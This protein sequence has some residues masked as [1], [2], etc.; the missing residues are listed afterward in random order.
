VAKEMLSSED[1]TARAEAQGKFFSDLTKLPVYQGWQPIDVAK[2]VAGFLSSANDTQKRSFYSDVAKYVPNF[3]GYTPDEVDADIHDNLLFKTPSRETLAPA[4]IGPVNKPLVD[5]LKASGSTS[6]GD[7]AASK[8]EQDSMPLTSSRMPVVRTIPAYDEEKSKKNLDLVTEYKRLRG[9]ADRMFADSDYVAKSKELTAYADKLNGDKEYRDYVQRANDIADEYQRLQSQGGVTKAQADDYNARLNALKQEAP[10]FT[11]QQKMSDRVQEVAADSAFRQKTAYHDEVMKQLQ[12]FSAEIQKQGEAQIRAGLIKKWGDNV[13]PSMQSKLDEINK[14]AADEKASTGWVSE[15]TAHEQAQ[16]KAAMDYVGQIQSTVLNSEDRNPLSELMSGLVTMASPSQAPFLADIAELG[17]NQ[18]VGRIREK[19]QSGRV[20]NQSETALLDSFDAASELLNLPG[21]QSFMYEMGKG[22]AALPKYAI[23]FALTEGIYKSSF[24]LAGR[25]IQKVLGETAYESLV[26]TAAKASLLESL[27]IKELTQLPKQLGAA[28]LTKAV[29]ATIAGTVQS[30]TNPF[31]I[32]ADVEQRVIPRMELSFSPAGE[33]INRAVSEQKPDSLIAAWMKSIGSN[34]SDYVTERWGVVV[35]KPYEFLKHQIIGKAMKRLGMD[36]FPP[37]KVMDLIRKKVAFNDWAGEFFE[38]YAQ[39]PIQTAIETGTPEFMDARTSLITLGVV[40]APSLGGTAV[41]LGLLPRQIKQER[42]ASERQA[43]MQRLRDYLNQPQKAK[44]A[45]P[46]DVG[47]KDAGQA[48]DMK[49]PVGQ[50]IQHGKEQE[51]VRNR[52]AQEQREY[53]QSK[54]AKKLRNVPESGVRG[55]AP[56]IQEPDMQTMREDLL[57]SPLPGPTAYELVR[58]TEPEIRNAWRTMAGMPPVQVEKPS[59]PVSPPT[60]PAAA[61]RGS[62]DEGKARKTI[63]GE[64]LIFKGY[65]EDKDPKN[66][67]YLFNDPISDSTLAIPIDKVTPEALQEVIKKSRRLNFPSL[68]KLR[69]A[70][71]TQEQIEGLKTKQEYNDL[72][73]KLSQPQ[74]P[75]WLQENIDQLNTQAER[76]N[77]GDEIERLSAQRLTRKEVAA[78]LRKQ[79]QNIPKDV[80]LDQLIYAVRAK[81]GIPSMDDSK[82]FENWL[83]SKKSETKIHPSKPGYEI[84]EA[85]GAFVVAHTNEEGSFIPNPKTGTSAFASLKEATDAMDREVEANYGTSLTTKAKDAGVAGREAFKK[86]LK[87]VPASDPALH[88]ILRD[89][90]VGDSAP[91]IKAWQ[92]AWNKANLENEPPAPK[93]QPPSPPQK[94]FQP[95]IDKAKQELEDIK[96]KIRDKLKGG[97]GTTSMLGTGAADPEMAVLAIQ[98][99]AKYAELGVLKFSQFAAEMVKDFGEAIKPYLKAAYGGASYSVDEDTRKQMDD[100]GTVRAFNLDSLKQE[101]DEEPADPFPLFIARIKKEMAERLK[102]MNKVDLRKIGAEYGIDDENVIKELTETAIVERARE[103]IAENPD[104]LDALKALIALYDRQPSLTHRTSESIAKQQYSTPAPLAFIAGAFTRVNGF[105]AIEPSAGNGM[106]TIGYDPQ[107]VWVNEID[108][109]RRANL[110]TQGF[111]FVTNQDA[112]TSGLETLKSTS[113]KVGNLIWNIVTNPPFGTNAESIPT[114]FDGYE[115]IKDD[116]VMTARSLRLMG[117]NARA[118]IIIGGNNEYN[119]DKR[120]RNDRIFFNWLYHF[121]N[122]NAIINVSGDLFRKQGASFPIRLI[123]VQGKKEKPEGA[124]PLRSDEGEKVYTS[125][126]DIY[127]RMKEVLHARPVVVQPSDNAE[128]GGGRPVRPSGRPQNGGGRTPT[129]RPETPATG[130][131]NGGSGSTPGSTGGG[132]STGTGNTRPVRQPQGGSTATNG[133]IQGTRGSLQP[134]EPITL[135]P[136]EQRQFDERRS[137]RDLERANTLESAG[138]DSLEVPYIPQSFGKRMSAMVPRSMAFDTY[139]AMNQLEDVVGSIDHFVLSELKYGSMEELY[140][141]LSADQIDAVAM[142]IRNIQIG[143]GSIVGDMT[144]T[145]KG[146]VAASVIRWAAKHGF[147]PIFFTK[148]KELFSDLYRDLVDTGN[149]DL[150]PFIVNSNVNI[151]D[152]FGDEI[153]PKMNAGKAKRVLETGD[154][155]GYDFVLATYSQVQN[156]DTYVT[157]PAFLQQI[158]PGSIIIMDESHNA[159]GKESNIGNEFAAYIDNSH[160]VVYLSATYAKRTDNM[161]VYIYK[162]VLREANATSDEIIDSIARGGVAMQEAIAADLTRSGQMIRR[163]RSFDGIAVDWKVLDQHKEQHTKTVDAVTKLIRD[164]IAFQQDYVAPVIGQMDEDAAEEGE[165]AAVGGRQ[166]TNLASVDNAPFV[167]KVHNVIDQLL[168]S[169]K[170]DDVAQ[171]AIAAVKNGEKPVIFF[172]NTMEAF[173]QDLGYNPGETVHNTDFA[174]VL[175]RGLK[176]VLRYTIRDAAGKQTHAALTP[177]QLGARGLAKFNEIASEIEKTSSGI[178]LSPIDRLRFL[179]GKQGIKVGEVTGRKITLKMSESGKA[180]V[181]HRKEK[182]E[183]KT[184]REFNN[185]G[186]DVLLLNVSGGTGASAHSSPKF[187]DKRPRVGI[188]HQPEL[189]ISEEMQKRGRINRFGQV[190]LPRYVYMSSAIPAERRIMMMLAGKLKSLDANT[191]SRQKSAMSLEG[192]V[193]FM[194]KYGDE[195]V[196]QYIKEDRDLAERLLDPFKFADKSDDE[197]EN[198]STAPNAV[199]RATN[200]VAL[201]P[202][203]EQDKFYDDVSQRYRDHLEYLNE[204]GENDL[205]L[206]ALPLNAKT[207]QKTVIRAG[208][209]GRSVF[210]T[211]SYLQTVEVDVLRKPWKKDE[212]KKMV[213]KELGKRTPEE[214][215]SEMLDDANAFAEEWQRK[216]LA[217][218]NPDNPLF[219]IRQ[220][221]L[222]SRLNA[223][224]RRT[225]DLIQ[226]FKIGTA[227]PMPTDFNDP[228]HSEFSPAFFMGFVINKKATNPYAPSA[229]KLRFAVNDFRRYVPIPGGKAALVNAILAGA[230]TYSWKQQRNDMISKWDERHTQAK[231]EQLAIV[232]GNILQGY[233]TDIAQHGKLISYTTNDGGTERGILLP[234]NQTVDVPDSVNVP[235]GRAMPYFESIARRD[236]IQTRLGAIFQKDSGGGWIL[237]V[238]ASKEKGGKFFLDDELAGLT[239]QGRFDKSGQFMTASVDAEKLKDVVELFHNKHHDTVNVPR[240]WSDTHLDSIGDSPDGNMYALPIV[241]SFYDKLLAPVSHHIAVAIAR[242]VQA[243]PESIQ[244][245]LRAAFAQSPEIRAAYEELR[246]TVSEYRLSINKLSRMVLGRDASSEEFI[247]LDRL[248]RG[249]PADFEKLKP[250]IQAAWRPIGSKWHELAQQLTMEMSLL[251]LPIREEWL[252]GPQHWYPNIWKH[253]FSRMVLG[254]LIGPNGRNLKVR[255]AEWGHTM[256][257]VVDKFAVYDQ[258]GDL[259]RTGTRLAI[260]DTMEEAQA[261]VKENGGYRIRYT[262]RETGKA[263]EETFDTPQERAKIVKQLYEDEAVRG[264]ISTPKGIHLTIMEPMTLEQ[265]IGHGLLEDPLINMRRGIREVGGLIAKTRFYTK[266]GQSAVIDDISTLPEDE[267]KNYVKLDDVKFKIPEKIA[268]ANEWTQRLTDGWV[269][270]SL[271]ED[272]MALYGPKGFGS[273][274]YDGLTRFLKSGLTVYNPF[275]Y[276]KQPVENELSLWFADS[277]LVLNIPAQTMAFTEYLD[278]IIRGTPNDFYDLFIKLGGDK[279]D[280]YTAEMRRYGKDISTFRDIEGSTAP[281]SFAEKAD[282]WLEQK[283]LYNYFADKADLLKAIYHHEDVIYRYYAFKRW[284]QKGMT[285]KQAMARVENS[286]FYAKETP[287][288]ITVISRHIPFAPRVTY[289]FGRIILTRLRDYPASTIMKLGLMAYLYDWLRDEMMKE[290]GWDDKAIQ[291]MGK[292]APSW[293]EIPLP[294]TD[295]QG[296]TVIMNLQWLLPFGELGMI[297]WDRQQDITAN[298]FRYMPLFFKGAVSTATGKTPWGYD[299]AKEGDPDWKKK[300]TV[301][302]LTQYMPYI[303]GTYWVQQYK[304]AASKAAPFSDWIEPTQKEYQV[305]WTEKAFVAPALG[306]L[307]HENMRTMVAKAQ[308]YV[309][310]QLKF[311]EDEK[312]AIE[313]DPNRASDITDVQRHNAR[314]AALLSQTA[315]EY[316]VPVTPELF[317]RY[318]IDVGTALQ[319]SMNKKQERMMSSPLERSF[320]R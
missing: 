53:Q 305:P 104:E 118:G 219:A 71:A 23:E 264:T 89:V 316:R 156:P 310:T 312:R 227:W 19:E 22:V 194:N 12:G 139:A 192:Q 79:G 95:N 114:D 144:G 268:N 87:S 26:Q 262:E 314:A 180:L 35:E 243:A 290:Q 126:E 222:I 199:R 318:I 204:A 88:E 234:R 11:E 166:G 237:K 251:G 141:A 21:V 198:S 281:L 200:R 247:A 82:E 84:R 33:I 188:I 46:P 239:R 190:T 2:D 186:L 15:D 129:V 29:P 119:D 224:Q 92:D 303:L 291:R 230:G 45:F 18:M 228:D 252:S 307:R 6:I 223:Q 99:A 294:I 205:E 253:H 195:I 226:S 64:G 309:M 14:K 220:A 50:F 3:S 274:L 136:Q 151:V 176:G 308:S 49:N 269:P 209:G 295:S 68:Q 319:K 285:P 74:S 215:Q 299:I 98:A 217:K 130:A 157:K 7:I 206:K 109:V 132:T 167:N 276:V 292:A 148:K 4:P 283:K 302:L 128:P 277:E 163:Q 48:P 225:A 44:L 254:H 231:R 54:Q 245:W 113:R 8:L 270:K 30:F 56:T 259:A 202:V 246:Q 122:V 59:S 300:A 91:I 24:K 293:T 73:K 110:S 77:L 108:P 34:A 32:A 236:N 177:D 284:V 85:N 133:V 178:S 196:Y 315:K 288:F 261:F 140:T 120:L 60:A 172:R 161:P 179:L 214:I 207:L 72:L 313:S 298:A 152:E 135:T 221:G 235:I 311:L 131:G 250:E 158:T 123:L 107:N 271:A 146:R 1:I 267:K 169:L 102:A 242:I 36:V 41:R 171:E 187:K 191:T 142:A 193:D 182:D 127:N 47:L 57:N 173:M 168:F 211:D 28:F 96:K 213:E 147:K 175:L 103:L 75:T 208:R 61:P 116:H 273:R 39:F 210:G 241:P 149:Q 93:P 272:L 20:L 165:G 189:D 297:G 66:D 174:I 143:E 90:K 25:G 289:E 138:I 286:F 111:A 117:E 55:V 134:S 52:I 304:N 42:V 320:D 296:K 255:T 238:P 69:D 317:N 244:K 13:L 27:G 101:Q 115:F 154:L 38:E 76:L 106:L 78:E 162:T 229:L 37:S 112:R 100:E 5:S 81:R 263:V 70:G 94:P 16:M 9:E 67:L 183:R 164:I 105:G 240:S 185:G 266:L 282:R 83:R 184:Y 40:A 212:V 97:M 256:A 124:A 58:M 203:A 275:R 153:I 80:D 65:Q 248:L 280:F 249:H 51:A 159:S 278:T 216:Q 257:R 306:G 63:E 43:A 31:K 155:S 201:L 86:G 10:K 287:R 233:T 301:N 145:G 170:V 181:E 137:A 125:F 279:E 197:I 265:M 218:L 150:K 232:T 121:Y 62:R 160:G 260:F 258:N 17:T